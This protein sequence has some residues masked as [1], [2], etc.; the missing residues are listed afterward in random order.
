VRHIPWRTW[1]AQLPRRDS[2][3]STGAFLACSAITQASRMANESTGFPES[4]GRVARVAREVKQRD[5]QPRH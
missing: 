2:P 3:E 5:A 4:L 1:E